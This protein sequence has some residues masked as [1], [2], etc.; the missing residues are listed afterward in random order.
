MQLKLADM[1][2]K[3][4]IKNCSDRLPHE[5]RCEIYSEAPSE[6]KKRGLEHC[7]AVQH[8]LDSSRSVDVPGWFLLIL[9]SP[10]FIKNI[11]NRPAVQ[12]GR[13]LL[14]TEPQEGMGS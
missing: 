12:Y 2:E 5:V 1:T 9:F 14:E 6:N 8:P 10:V 4:K 11:F 13:V 7:T 3:G